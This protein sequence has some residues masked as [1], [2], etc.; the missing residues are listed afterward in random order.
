L[1]EKER[2]AWPIGYYPINSDGS[3]SEYD[4][5]NPPIAADGNYFWQLNEDI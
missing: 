4:S 2:F 1:T 5:A 3:Y